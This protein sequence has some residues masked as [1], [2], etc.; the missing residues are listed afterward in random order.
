MKANLIIAFFLSLMLF[1]LNGR[2]QER[3][4]EVQMK[5]I[6]GK[7]FA[8]GC[9]PGMMKIKDKCSKSVAHFS[10]FSNW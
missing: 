5:L 10:F 7:D 8:V 6:E 9:Y 3:T 4:I 2:A 1:T